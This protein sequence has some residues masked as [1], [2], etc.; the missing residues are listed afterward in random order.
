MER[1]KQFSLYSGLEGPQGKDSVPSL[2]RFRVKKQGRRKRLREARG[3]AMPGDEFRFS[4]MDSQESK[5]G[6][7]S[8]LHTTASEPRATI[9]E[10]SLCAPPHPSHNCSCIH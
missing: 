5:L 10:Y 6:E 2:H 8:L 3:V 9:A 4:F 1:V 7:D